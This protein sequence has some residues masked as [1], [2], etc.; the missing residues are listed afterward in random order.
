[1]HRPGWVIAGVLAGLA[2]LGCGKGAEEKAADTATPPPG[3]AAPAAE[4]A[5]AFAA[6]ESQ[7]LVPKC[8]HADGCHAGPVPAGGMD[9]GAGVAYQDLVGVKATRRPERL[10]VAPGDPEGSYLLNRLTPGGDTP[11][12][13]LGGPSLSAAEIDAIR[14][15]VRD[16]ARR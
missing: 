8:A 6:V 14:A 1:M 5:G 11:P 3:N 4:P 12:M 15:W 2:A 13:P 10:R 16:G 7:I 9:L